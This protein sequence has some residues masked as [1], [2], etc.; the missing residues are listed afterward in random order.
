ME[1]GDTVSYLMG[2]ET[3]DP[4][5]R[6]I[7][8]EKYGLDQPIYIQFI[9]YIGQVLSGDLGD[10]IIYR[11]PVIDMIF[12]KIGPTFLIILAG[13]AIALVIGTLAG[14]YSARHEGKPLDIIC[15]G[16]A[17]AM[18]AMPSFWLALML[19]ILLASTLRIFPTSGM[20]TARVSLTGF[21]Y[22]L[23]VMYH[24]ALP[25][26]TIVLLDIPYYFRVAKSSVMQATNEEFIM[27]FRATGMSDRKIFT[28]YVL[29]NAMLPIITVLGITISFM[30]AGVALIEIVFAWPGTG[31][32][33]LS[34]IMQRD[35][36]TL[37]GMF[38]ITSLC[39]AVTMILVDL[40]YAVFDPRIS[41]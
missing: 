12:E 35:Y 9:K 40:L 28:K 7:L 2:K 41:Y 5:M 36:P 37:M 38:T 27:T 13:T 14:V 21:A 18:N 31:R 20:T 10:S 3:N 23:N 30:I 11:R 29:K 34:A 16:F 22:V 6:Q 24:M 39:I 26:L 15:S 17:Y 4:Q 19:I 8:M 25:V 33:T 1:P 32:L